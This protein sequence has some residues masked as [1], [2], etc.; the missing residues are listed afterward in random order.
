MPLA[1]KISFRYLFSRKRK[2]FISFMSFVSILGV[3][4]GV[5][6][7]IT[8]LAVMSGFGDELQKRIIGSNPHIIIEKDGGIGFDELLLISKRA[9]KIDHIKGISPHVW[10]QGV[11]KFRKRAQGVVVRS[12]DAKNK[13]DRENLS[14]HMQVGDLNLGNDE[15]ILGNELA[16]AL[17]VFTGD[18]I[19]VVTSSA[20]KPK[21]HKIRG[22]FSSGMYEY[23]LNMAY[24]SLNSASDLFGMKDMV[25]GIG[26]YLDDIAYAKSTKQRLREELSNFFYIRTW[27]D[28]NRNLFSALKLEKWAMFVILT[29]IIIVAA[30][31][32]V[33]TLTV[34][35]VEK[36]KDIGI[37]KAIG[38]TRGQIM[39]AFSFQGI[40]IGA[41]GIILGGAG[42]LGIS[43]LLDR[44][45]FPI[46]PENIYY[47]INYLPVKIDIMDSMI[48]L[49]AALLISFIAS[50]YPAYQASR[51]SPVDALRYE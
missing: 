11:L 19:E 49:A 51:L 14:T 34:M 44:Y 41:I 30:L 48:I 39:A 18:E 8:V 5:G 13:I 6:C 32:I 47:G 2:K 26:V 21:K 40:I 17:G 28:L 45:R 29:L 25:G 22:I 1:L 27:M 50:I 35:V 9:Q 12:F 7:L 42:G 43:F 24:V 16:S 15:V 31:N 46:L 33:S 36:T 23:D 37:L 4:V 38:V 10:G 20:R 3:A